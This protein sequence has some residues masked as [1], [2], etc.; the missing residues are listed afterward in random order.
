MA[1]NVNELAK[2]DHLRMAGV[3]SLPMNWAVVEVNELLS[4]DR[5]ISVGVMYPGDH[6]PTGIPLIKAGDLDGDRVNPRPKFRITPKK[7]YDYRRTE[8]AGGEILM[9]LVGNVGQCAVAPRSMAGWNTARAVAVMR[10]KDES[11]AHFVRLCL[12]S[13][14]LRHL[15]DVW[16]NTTVQA[17]LNLKE[18]RQLPLPWP[19]KTERDAI[20]SLANALDDKIE[21]NR[22]MNRTLEAMARAIFKSWFVDFDPVKAKA[23]KRRE[24]PKWT[25]AEVNRAACPNL[26]PKL[27]TLFPDNFAD[28][29]IDSIPAGWNETTV[30][31]EAD[32]LAGFA[33]KSA[34]HR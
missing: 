12:M 29:S 14:P 31:S 34:I 16:C 30:G 4:D 11:D 19:P 13:R 23:A 27:A 7:H 3:D 17:T 6:D 10:L 26:N 5:G 8:L 20:T 1:A 9:T 33:F 18:I 32:Y 28:V 24:H 2:Y 25:D 21:L 15:I 22:R